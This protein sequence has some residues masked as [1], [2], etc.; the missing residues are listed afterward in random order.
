ML[1]QHGMVVIGN[2]TGKNSKSYKKNDQICLDRPSRS[3]VRIAKFK[4]LNWIPVSERAKQ[5]NL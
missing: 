2:F 3:Q 1:A 5:I 4:V